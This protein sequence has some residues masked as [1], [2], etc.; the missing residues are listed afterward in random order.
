[1]PKSVALTAE[2]CWKISGLKPES[3]PS[4]SP[5]TNGN[6]QPFDI[7]GF[8]AR[9]GIAT[10]ETRPHEG[11]T[12]Y[13]LQECVFDS[14]H[15][16]KDAAIIQR[17]SG[18]LG[19]KCWHDSC[20]SRGWREVRQKF[21]PGCYDKRND[22][23]THDV[24][25]KA[26]GTADEAAAHREEN[27]GLPLSLGEL[28]VQYPKLPEQIIH[29]LLRVGETMNVIAASKVGKSWIIYLFALCIVT[30]RRLWDTFGIV[31]G[32]VLILDNELF[33]EVSAFR[34]PLVAKALGLDPEDCDGK[35]FVKNLRGCLLDIHG[36]ARYLRKNV[37]P[38]QYK[39]IVIDA[40]YRILPEGMDENGNS[41][42]TQIYNQ[43]DSLSRELG[44]AFILVH[45]SS[46]GSQS[47]KA[48]TD[49]GAGAGAQSRAADVHLVLRP[50]EEPGVVVA[51]AALRSQP[52]LEPICLRF[53]ASTFPLWKLVEGLDA[54]A[55]KADKP[56]TNINQVA[57]RVLKCLKEHGAQTRTACRA[58]LQISGER[59]NQA[60]EVLLAQ[61]EIEPIE[62][63]TKSG[64]KTGFQAS[65]SSSDTS[66]SPTVRPTPGSSDGQP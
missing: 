55:L 27:I 13:V 42:T 36:I 15:K 5:P 34:L 35:L 20:S 45:H 46:K 52:P 44:C 17:A 8:I 38:G 2:N 30:G 61:K 26:R 66:D 22:Y 24:H 12:I 60:I 51:E 4:N 7:A 64:M 28:K 19:Y 10:K 18:K 21:E 48:V 49:V 11:G 63:K 62:I 33:P 57:E 29:G 41:P 47:S 39:V 59:L 6:G 40:Y 65:K 37:K 1:M 14:S 3:E 32:D 58:K 25:G 43:I 23:Q 54:T 50:H 56:K 9:H 53:D 31:P 16:G